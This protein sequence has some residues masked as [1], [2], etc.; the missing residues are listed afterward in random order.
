[1][2]N[3]KRAFQMLKLRIEENQIN[4]ISKSLDPTGSG[5]VNYRDFMSFFKPQKVDFYLPAVA[6]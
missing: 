6:R 4:F 5:K 1:M 2:Q 3:F